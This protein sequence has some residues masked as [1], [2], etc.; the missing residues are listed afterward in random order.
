LEGLVLLVT[1]SSQAEAE[2]IAQKV[3]EHRLAACVTILPPVQSVFRWEGKINHETEI[4]LIIKSQKSVFEPLRQLLLANH[5]Y[6]VPE[7]IALP[8]VAGLPEYLKWLEDET[9]PDAS[10]GEA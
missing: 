8:I 6:Q 4:L 10:G 5:S 1:A 7:I 9:H 2:K 3:V